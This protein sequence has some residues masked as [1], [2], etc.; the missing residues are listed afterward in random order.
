MPPVH[1]FSELSY[2]KYGKN[3]AEAG[4]LIRDLLLARIEDES[5]FDAEDLRVA[6]LKLEE[7]LSVEFDLPN[8]VLDSPDEIPF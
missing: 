1:R 4:A 3:V 7:L 6:I 5:Q 8:Y 2:W